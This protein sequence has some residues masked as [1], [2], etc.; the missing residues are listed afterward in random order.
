M[1]EATHFLCPFRDSS[2]PPPQSFRLPSDSELLVCSSSR[3]R[4]HRHQDTVPPVVEIRTG[5]S[6]SSWRV[7]PTLLP[8]AWRPG[9]RFLVSSLAPAITQYPLVAPG[10]KHPLLP[11]C[12]LELLYKLFPVPDVNLPPLHGFSPVSLLH[13]SYQVSS[14][15]RHSQQPL[16]HATD[17]VGSANGGQPIAP[18]PASAGDQSDTSVPP[19]AFLDQPPV[20]TAQPLFPAYLLGFL[21]GIISEV[22]SASVSVV[23]SSPENQPSSQLL[24]SVTQPSPPLS[25]LASVPPE[26]SA[27][28]PASTSA[29]DR[30]DTSAPPS[31]VGRPDA[32]AQASTVGRPDASAP[33]SAVG[34]CEASAPA[35]QSSASSSSSSTLLAQSSAPSSSSSSSTLLAKTLSSSLPPVSAEG[36]PVA[37]VPVLSFERGL[38]VLQGS[39]ADLRAHLKLLWAHLQLLRTHLQLIRAHLQLLRS[40]RLHLKSHRDTSG[41]R[42]A[43]QIDCRCKSPASQLAVRLPEP[44]PA[45]KTTE[46]QVVVPEFREG[47]KSEPP[48]TQ[49][50]EFREGFRKK[51]PLAKPPEP[52]HAAKPSQP[53][54]AVKSSE[55]Q[56]DSE[57]FHFDPDFDSDFDPDF[58]PDSK[59]DSKASYSLPNSKAPDSKHRDTTTHSPTD[60]KSD[61]QL[62]SRPPEFLLG[63]K[64]PEFLFRPKPPVFLLGHKHPEFLLDLLTEG[65]LLC[66]ADLLTEGPRLGLADL[67]TEGP[68]LGSAELLTEGPLL[69]SAKLLT[70][71][72][73]LCSAGLQIVGSFI[74]HFQI[75]SFFDA[76]SFAADLQIISSSDTSFFAADLKI[77]ISFYSPCG[78]LAIFVIRVLPPNPQ[79]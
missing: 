16:L 4:R 5:A 41:S 75:V 68:L 35:D 69:G 78:R 10:M 72:S 28:A 77:V 24:P 32:S 79:P 15:L 19:S 61:F 62:D 3:Q 55:P 36:C 65:P 54:H 76:G 17:D 56:P 66:S 26:G 30:P 25:H 44:W 20:A 40:H 8:L 45:D 39:I 21:W 53:Q 52:Q 57:T 48:L 71:G 60:F 67:L 22:F 74:T 64:P 12:S 59:P 51:T 47:F 63:P 33:A 11:L 37:P 14:A 46:L 1:L 23:H 42:T 2:T 49:V 29:V 18:A 73:L 43:S 27:D 7:W 6:K 9:L 38:R 31:V 70:E 13:R 50:P 34:R 58:D